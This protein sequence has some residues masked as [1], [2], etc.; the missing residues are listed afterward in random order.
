[1][2]G[3]TLN[4]PTVISRRDLLKGAAAAAGGCLTLPMSLQGADSVAPK[5][6]AA[7]VTRYEK[8]LHADVLIG[9]IMEGWKQ[10]GGTGPALKLASMYVDQYG[11]GDLARGLAEKYNVPLFDTI[12]GAVT[13][14]GNSIPVDGVISVGEH[15]DY[16]YNDKEQHLYPRRRFFSE[17]TDTF[18]KYGRVVPVFNDKHLGPQWDDAKW[19]YDRAQELKVPFMAGSS[20]V[21]TYRDPELNLPMGS[22]IEAAV[23]IGYSGLDIYAAHALEVFQCLVERRRGAEKGV[24]WVQFLQGDAMWKAIDDGRVSSEIFH[25]AL[26]LVAASPEGVRQ[27][28]DASLFLFQYRDGLLGTLFMLPG[29]ATGTAIALKVKGQQ[30]LLATRFEERTQP[31]HPH[32]AYLLKGIERMIHTGKPSYP[33]ERTLLTSGILDRA[34]TSRL[35]KQERL[36]TPELEIRYTPVDYPHAPFPELTSRPAGG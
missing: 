21:V 13:V 10:D 6:V 36:V 12:E 31:R 33:V 35:L 30:Q 24:E 27:S 28:K 16:P 19:M 22:D 9:K 3:S 20:L 32:F 25:A 11:P 2:K 29:F 26:A 8:G 1:M 18:R 5:S 15:G 34:L 17:I 4:P 14:G 7:V 23:A